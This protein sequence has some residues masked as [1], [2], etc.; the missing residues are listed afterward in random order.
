MPEMNSEIDA[1]LAQEKLDT[2]LEALH[3]ATTSVVGLQ[4]T[5]IASVAVTDAICGVL[6]NAGLCTEADLL[7]QTAINIAGRIEEMVDAGILPEDTLDF[8]NT[9]ADEALEEV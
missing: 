1:A 2:V 9:D 6:I 8:Q 5:T 7:Q 4:A 3:S